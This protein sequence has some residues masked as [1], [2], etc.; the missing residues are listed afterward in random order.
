[1]LGGPFLAYDD[2]KVFE[3]PDSSGR[4]ALLPLPN[5]SED[6]EGIPKY[7]FNRSVFDFFGTGGERLVS[8]LNMGPGLWKHP[9]SI[10]K[11]L[12][13]LA[14]NLV[15]LAA[16]PSETGEVANEVVRRV[17]AYYGFSPDAEDIKA[18]RHAVACGRLHPAFISALFI[19]RAGGMRGLPRLDELARQPAEYVR[20]VR[21]WFDSEAAAEVFPRAVLAWYTRLDGSRFKEV[22]WHIV[23]N[24][25][26]F[27]YGFDPRIPATYAAIAGG[28]TKGDRAEVA[29]LA[30]IDLELGYGGMNWQ[31]IGAK[32]NA[33]GAQQLVQ[34]FGAKWKN[35][36][37]KRAHFLRLYGHDFRQCVLITRL[38]DLANESH[39]LMKVK[40]ADEPKIKKHLKKTERARKKK[41]S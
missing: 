3:A 21:Q 6:A 10:R 17:A 38:L 26:D 13:P 2:S 28:M 32:E 25:D 40:R 29:R 19:A 24:R 7:L 1:M 15:T 37:G 27:E 18:V 22:L 23:E 5:V 11:A 34:M 36:Y 9:P 35:R 20:K 4:T 8:A 12:L 33:P 30:R 14:R 31:V 16:L 41:R 39:A